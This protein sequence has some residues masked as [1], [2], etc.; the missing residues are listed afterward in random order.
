MDQSS[1]RQLINGRTRDSL[2]DGR[3]FDLDH[4]KDIS[5]GLRS[6]SSPISLATGT[7]F[8]IY[9]NS[10][11]PAMKA[12]QQEVILV[13]CFWADSAT[14]SAINDAL[15]HLSEKAT[16]S[17]STISVRICF[18]SSSLPRNLLLPTP[19]RGQNY[20]PPTWDKLGLPQPDELAGLNMTITRKFFWP[21]GIIHSKYVIVDRE[22]AIFPSCNVSWE[23]WFEV[24][25]SLQGPVVGHLLAFHTE[26]WDNGNPLAPIHPSEARNEISSLIAQIPVV[27]GLAETAVFDHA[28]HSMTLLPSPHMSTLLPNHLQPASI[29]GHLPCFPG[30]SHTFPS[31]PL[32]NTTHH[33]LFTAKSSIVML[34]PNLTEPVVIED[35]IQALERGVDVHIWTNR[36]LMTMEQIVT[37]GTTTPRCLRILAKRSK[38]LRGSLQ[39]VFFDD[40]PGAWEGGENAKDITPIKLHSKV[41][42]IDGEKILLGSCNMDAASWKTSQE[43]GIL[44]ESR[45][46]VEEFKR[47]WKYGGLE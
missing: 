5:V 3:S 28:R 21:F 10:I 12:A 17:S 42:I 6:T 15:R 13:T 7:G 29:L 36:K 45:E 38:A 18:S 23:R 40:G 24:A 41:T 16:A 43:L 25:I 4:I 26:F 22:I 19:K 11:I 32:L 35:L 47:T 37:A 30:I 8:S 9:Q 44:V 27:D 1:T 46:V 14:L 34:T 2:E 31:T 39:T 20:P 33:L